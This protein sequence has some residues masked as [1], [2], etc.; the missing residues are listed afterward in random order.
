MCP[1]PR[2]TPEAKVAPLTCAQIA[3]RI[4]D[5]HGETCHRVTVW[6]VIRNLG[7]VPAIEAGRF[8]FYGP[9]VV[10]Q[11]FQALRSTKAS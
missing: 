6:R 2:K 8:S 9:E 11:V 7:I 4:K 1:S 10:D 5:I 3:K